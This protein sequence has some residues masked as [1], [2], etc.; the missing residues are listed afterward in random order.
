[1]VSKRVLIAGFL[2][3]GLLLTACSSIEIVG[4]VLPPPTVTPTASLPPPAAAPVGT[5]QPADAVTEEDK[6][7]LLL[8]TP[9][10][11]PTATPGPITGLVNSITYRSGLSRV[12]FLG[13]KVDDWI[14]LG[15]SLIIVLVAVLVLARII[16]SL[17]V[18]AAGRSKNEYVA[19]YL[20]RIQRQITLLV[21]IFSLQYATVRLA[22]LSPEVKAFWIAP[23]RGCIC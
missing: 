19:F 4:T 16:F 3:V 9:T 10:P 13:L 1:M 2:L 11:A 21:G 15:I 18:R 20:K 5:P 8:D 7:G 14:N 12:T 23:I 17:L 22:F 6:S